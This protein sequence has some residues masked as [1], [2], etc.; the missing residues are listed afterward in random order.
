MEI[1]ISWFL[2]KPTDLDLHCLQRQGISGFSRT[3]VKW[4]RYSFWGGNIFENYFCLRFE[5][6][7]TLKWMERIS[8]Q[9]VSKVAVHVKTAGKVD[10]CN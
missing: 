9:Q 4:N 3:R 8:K 10:K 7:S 2:Q 5:K 6:Q 1:Q